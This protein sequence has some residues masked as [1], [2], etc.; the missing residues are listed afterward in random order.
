MD[1]LEI[2]YRDER[3]ALSFFLREEFTVYRVYFFDQRMNCIEM[4]DR[5]VA[6]KPHRWAQAQVKRNGW[7]T[8]AIGLAG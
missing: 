5:I 6:H 2:M 8:Y 7:Y 1:A 4:I 3:E